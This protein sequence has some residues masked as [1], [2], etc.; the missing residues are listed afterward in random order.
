MRAQL[1]QQSLNPP[2]VARE[3]RCWLLSQSVKVEIAQPRVSLNLLYTVTP[4]SVER[5]KKEEGGDGE[6]TNH[7]AALQGNH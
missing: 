5:K 3:V 2:R 4:K 6:C 1:V 7:N